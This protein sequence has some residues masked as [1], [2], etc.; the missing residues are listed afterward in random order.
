MDFSSLVTLEDWTNALDQLIV[1][2][3]TAIHNNNQGKIAD[4]Q[5]DLFNYQQIS[6]VNFDS[7]DSIAA[8]L[9][10]ELNRANRQIALKNI[11]EIADELKN[12]KNIL[13]VATEH[14]NQ[15]ADDIQLKSTKNFLNKAKTSLTI[16]KGLRNDLTDNSTDLGRKVTAVFK[17]IQEF[18]EAFPEF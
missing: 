13:G 5:D 12:L 1:A 14:A 9:S 6:P 8:K 10:L 16:L 3:T 11:A 7:L 4:L 2:S 17:A 15:S 18:E